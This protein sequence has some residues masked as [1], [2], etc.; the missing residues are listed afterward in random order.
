MRLTRCA[1]R[2]V[3][4]SSAWSWHSAKFHWTSAVGQGLPRCWTAPSPCPVGTVLE[5]DAA[6]RQA[7]QPSVTRAGGGAQLQGWPGWGGSV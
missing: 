7:A 2:P 3:P 1:S 6:K 5:T 4:W